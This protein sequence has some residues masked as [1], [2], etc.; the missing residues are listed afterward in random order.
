LL[1]GP[2]VMQGYFGNPK[3]TAETFLEGGWMRTGD[4][5][6]RAADG[7]YTIVDRRKELIKYK[8]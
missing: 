4:V 7:D 6:V 3:A 8:G 1:R 2:I 5:A